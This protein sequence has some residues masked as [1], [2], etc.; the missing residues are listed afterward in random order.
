MVQMLA[1]LVRTVISRLY[2]GH[3]ARSITYRSELRL[4]QEELFA[5]STQAV[6]LNLVILHILSALKSRKEGVTMK[7]EKVLI[8]PM[9]PPLLGGRKVRLVITFLADPMHARRLSMLI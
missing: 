7:A 4:L 6:L 9:A 1:T 8:D 3:S 5:L 2:K